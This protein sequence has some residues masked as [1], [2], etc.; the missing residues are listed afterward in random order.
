MAFD[1]NTNGSCLATASITNSASPHSCNSVKVTPTRSNTVRNCSNS[2]LSKHDNDA[3][4]N[5]DDED[6]DGSKVGD[7]NDDDAVGNVGDDDDDDDAI[8]DGDDLDDDAFDGVDSI[9]RPVQVD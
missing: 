3:V 7:G 8:K 9:D 5:D 2:F 4:G 1:T 6:D